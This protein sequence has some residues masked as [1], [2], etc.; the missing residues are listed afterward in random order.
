M[1]TPHI[2]DLNDDD[3][4]AKLEHLWQRRKLAHRLDHPD[5]RDPDYG[6]ENMQGR[7]DWVPGRTWTHPAPRRG[8]K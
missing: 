2:D 1:T 3:I 4:D 7:Y 5:D 6:L 8:G